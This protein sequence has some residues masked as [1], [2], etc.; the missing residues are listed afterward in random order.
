M[1][2]KACTATYTITNAWQGGFQADVT[3]RNSGASAVSGWRVA[4]SFPNGQTISQLWSGTVS[5]SGS[6][7]TVQNLSWNGNLSAGATTSFGFTGTGSGTVPS[8]VTCTA[9]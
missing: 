8:S 6:N 5:Q 2:G 7:V 4:W 1:T 9:A 3:V